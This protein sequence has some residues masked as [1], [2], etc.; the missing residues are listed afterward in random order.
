VTLE[1][2]VLNRVVLREMP[3]ADAVGRGLVR[4]EGD[5]ARVVELFSLLAIS[6]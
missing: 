5:P 3:F 1:R 4:I 6:P 2:A